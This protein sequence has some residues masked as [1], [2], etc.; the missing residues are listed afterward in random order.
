QSLL[1][2]RLKD[3]KTDSKQIAEK[4]LVIGGIIGVAYLLVDALL[5]DDD[6]TPSSSVKRV[7]P[8]TER[9]RRSQDSWITKAI[10]S[11]ALTS[12]LE[13][14]RQKLIDY[15]STQQQKNEVNPTENPQP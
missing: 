15:L 8:L 7:E 6:Q 10:V 4:A 11:F 1:E 5:P 2:E 12:A 3:L 9:P 13:L 14:A